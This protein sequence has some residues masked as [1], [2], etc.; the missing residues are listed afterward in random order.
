M[1][2]LGAEVMQIYS[3]FIYLN[4][5][6]ICLF[7]TVCQQLCPNPHSNVFPLSLLVLFLD[8]FNS[9]SLGSKLN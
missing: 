1:L 8:H 7:F 2:I 3:H 5:T 6:E 9:R 4:T